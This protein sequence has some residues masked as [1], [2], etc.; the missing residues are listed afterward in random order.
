MGVVFSVCVWG[1]GGGGSVCVCGGGGGGGVISRLPYL[2]F[3]MPYLLGKQLNMPTEIYVDM[4]G[5]N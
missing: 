2:T 3:L 5:F 4:C 1:G